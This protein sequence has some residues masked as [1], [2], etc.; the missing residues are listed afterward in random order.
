MLLHILPVMDVNCKKKKKCVVI[1]SVINS[2][3]HRPDV[4]FMQPLYMDIIAMA[5]CVIL[6]LLIRL[7]A[8]CLCLSAWLFVAVEFF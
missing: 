4:S 3:S 2:I 6:L 7:M 8:E 5:L 1:I